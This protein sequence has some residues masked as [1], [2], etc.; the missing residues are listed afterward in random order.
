[1]EGTSTHFTVTEDRQSNYDSQL[2]TVGPV[3]ANSFVTELSYA[4]WLRM[5]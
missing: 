2:N 5:M 3:N 4:F 1:M